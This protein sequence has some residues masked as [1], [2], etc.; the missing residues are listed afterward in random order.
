MSTRSKACGQSFEGHEAGGEIDHGLKALIGLVIAS[1]DAAELLQGAE[2]VLDEMPPAIHRKVTRN[3]ART[4]GF[5][6][7]D[8]GRTTGIQFLAQ[9]IIVEA[10]VSNQSPDLDPIEQGLGSDTV[11]ALPR[12]KQKV[13]QVAERIHQGHDFGGQAAAGA[14]DGLTTSPPLAPVPC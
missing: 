13:R 4:I 12:Q 5:G 3:L 7:D 11:M 10:L 1:G 9:R 8:S 14:P 6:R 2:E